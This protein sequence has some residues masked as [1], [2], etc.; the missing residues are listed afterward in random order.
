MYYLLLCNVYGMKIFKYTILTE[1]SLTVP[2]R[3]K[4]Q[5]IIT[6]FPE[7]LAFY[8]PFFIFVS[9]DPT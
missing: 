4:T 2:G 7:L 5:L 8:I 6:I 3:V 9:R 1:I